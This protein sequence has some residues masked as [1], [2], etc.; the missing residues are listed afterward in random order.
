LK[1]VEEALLL[2]ERC[3][4]SRFVGREKTHEIGEQNGPNGVTFAR[5]NEE[6]HPLSEV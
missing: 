3:D 4:V 6:I 1:N 2:L 5:K